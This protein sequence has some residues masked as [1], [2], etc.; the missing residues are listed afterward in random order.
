[1]H[2]YEMCL[3]NY[4]LYI[5]FNNNQYK[6]MNPDQIWYLLLFWSVGF[7]NQFTKNV[8]QYGFL[9]GFLSLE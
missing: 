7:L 6:T 3:T 9:W 2:F 5:D 8:F 1:M 4:N